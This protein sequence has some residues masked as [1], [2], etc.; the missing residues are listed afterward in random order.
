MAN[1]LAPQGQ[2]ITNW[3]TQMPRRQTHHAGAD[4]WDRGYGSRRDGSP[5]GRGYLGLL[6]R[7]DGDNMTEYTVGIEMDGQEIDIPSIVPTLDQSEIDHLLN[8]SDGDRMPQN[9]M[10]KAHEHAMQRIQQ[11][12]SPFY[13]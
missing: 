8:M 1:A 3:L 9:I 12:L 4:T 10:K 6:K 11:G 7:P 2:P 13:D 5:K